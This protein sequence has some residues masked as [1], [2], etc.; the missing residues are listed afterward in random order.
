[1]SKVQIDMPANFHFSKT[2][3]VRVSD[4][5]YGKHV[6]NDTIARYVNEAR[7]AFLK[8]LGYADEVSIEG[9]GI[10]MRDS[11]IVFKSEGFLGDQIRIDTTVQNMSRSGFDFMHRLFNETQNRDP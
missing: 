10:I 7:V 4:I 9:L 2:L 5:N 1:M 6:A 3:E 8:S 11:A